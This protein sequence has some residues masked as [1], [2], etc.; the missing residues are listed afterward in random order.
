MKE[1]DM[2]DLW[3]MFKKPLL[4]AAED[5]CGNQKCSQPKKKTR[6]WKTKVQEIVSKKKENW[7]EKKINHSTL[8]IGTWNVKM[9][10]KPRKTEEAVKKLERY[11][12]DKTGLQEVRKKINKGIE[13]SGCICKREFII[14]L[15]HGHEVTALADL[16]FEVSI[17]GVPLFEVLDVTLSTGSDCKVTTA[18]ETYQDVLGIV[19]LPVTLKDLTTDQRAKLEKI[20]QL[21]TYLQGLDKIHLVQ[22]QM[23]TADADKTAIPSGFAGNPEVDHYGVGSYVRSESSPT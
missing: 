17:I 4:E 3:I 15:A 21:F 12:V 23:D 11:Q 6:W 13:P 18:N 20:A 9:L 16:G 5:V 1:S 2:E 22:H 10:L 19:Q 14:L 7:K 8:R